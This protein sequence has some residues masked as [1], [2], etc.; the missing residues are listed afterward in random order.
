MIYDELIIQNI[1]YDSG[2]TK[3]NLQCLNIFKIVDNS[4]RYIPTA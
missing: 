2:A 1:K 4:S 3:H